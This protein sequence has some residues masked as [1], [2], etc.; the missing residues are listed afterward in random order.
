MKAIPASLEL[1][2][3]RKNSKPR[4]DGKMGTAMPHLRKNRRKQP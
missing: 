1:S 2:T 4:K 3:E